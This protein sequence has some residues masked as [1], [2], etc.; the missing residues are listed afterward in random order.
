MYFA[1]LIR[2]S[3]ESSDKDPNTNPDYKTLVD[4]SE[5]ALGGPHPGVYSISKQ[6]SDFKPGLSQVE[7]SWVYQVKLGDVPMSV[8]VVGKAEG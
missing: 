7:N 6:D 8:I 5:K 3:L 1:F 2:F 4:L